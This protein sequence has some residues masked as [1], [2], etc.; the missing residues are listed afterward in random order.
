MERRSG[1]RLALLAG[2]EE[3]TPFSS[4]PSDRR[5]GASDHSAMNVPA[6]NEYYPLR[7]SNPC[8]R[9]EKT[10]SSPLDERDHKPIL[11]ITNLRSENRSQWFVFVSIRN[12][13]FRLCSCWRFLMGMK[14]VVPPGSPTNQVRHQPRP[15]PLSDHQAP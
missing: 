4:R 6:G 1:S 12:S 9:H 3:G 14:R 7:E 2:R 8:L 11:H 5:D 10:M 13:I 15:F